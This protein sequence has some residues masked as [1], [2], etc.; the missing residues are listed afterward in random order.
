M[1][2]LGAVRLLAMGKNL[3]SEKHKYE[4]LFRF[5]NQMLFLLES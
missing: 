3:F 5:Q 4:N 2:K 1:R